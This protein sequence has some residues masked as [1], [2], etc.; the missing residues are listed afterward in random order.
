VRMAAARIALI[1]AFMH[2]GAE[3]GYDLNGFA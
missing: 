2:D 1:T 3:E